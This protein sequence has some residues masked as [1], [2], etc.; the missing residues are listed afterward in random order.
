MNCTAC[1]QPLVDVY[2]EYILDKAGNVICIPCR[3]AARN[4]VRKETVNA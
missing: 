1:D 4:D 3:D 2:I